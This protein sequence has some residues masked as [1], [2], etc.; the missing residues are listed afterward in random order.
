MRKN[1]KG[2]TYTKT[3]LNE[4]MGKA[5][6]GA[7]KRMI[8]DMEEIAEHQ[9]FVI[10]KFSDMVIEPM[11]GKYVARITAQWERAR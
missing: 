6:E 8:D 5:R 4:P 10:R 11:Y 3:F 9:G 7:E 1:K 2:F